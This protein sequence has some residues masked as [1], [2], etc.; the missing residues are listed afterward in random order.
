MKYVEHTHFE[1]ICSYKYNK[2]VRS[3]YLSLQ[4]RVKTKVEQWQ[5]L[6]KGKLFIKQDDRE[7]T[8]KMTEELDKNI[9]KKC[10]SSIFQQVE[11][12][13][14]TFK[15]QEDPQKRETIDLSFYQGDGGD[16]RI[17]EI[18]PPKDQHQDQEQLQKKQQIEY[19]ACKFC[20]QEQYPPIKK[21]DM[22]Q[23]LTL[24]PNEDATL[25]CLILQKKFEIK[26][27]ILLSE[28]Y[29]NESIGLSKFRSDCIFRLDDEE[30]R[31]NLMINLAQSSLEE[32]AQDKTLHKTS[33]FQRVKQKNKL[34]ENDSIVQQISLSETVRKKREKGIISEA[35]QELGENLQSLN[36]QLILFLEDY[37]NP[38]LKDKKELH[39]FQQKLIHKKSKIPDD[40]E[41]NP[42]NPQP[43]ADPDDTQKTHLLQQIYL[44]IQS[45]F[46]IIILIIFVI[47]HIKNT[48]LVSLVYPFSF[49]L[50][51]MIEYPYPS[52]NYW[53]L[54]LTY[55]IAIIVIKFIYQVPIFC[56]SPAYTLST[57]N[58]C[59]NIFYTQSE[60]IVRIDYLIGIK[61][62]SG[63]SS[64]PHD[65]GFFNAVFWDLIV[66]LALLFQ[67]YIMQEQGLWNYVAVKN[68]DFYIPQFLK[69][70]KKE[71]QR[72]KKRDEENANSDSYL[73]NSSFTSESSAPS[74]SQKEDGALKKYLMRLNPKQLPVSPL[75]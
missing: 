2:V 68:S 20:L 74:E 51:A 48:N 23:L 67:R 13:K 53:K 29:P 55:T 28:I 33:W 7:L 50:Y 32:V 25:D 12:E 8:K 1:K 9:L 43:Q 58:S 15:P 19:K 42:Q 59:Q 21:K 54:I 18:Q 3:T 65:Q 66:L 10:S 70:S 4:Q 35:F 62:Y 38:I 57:S 11:E 40:F 63:P 46:E 22:I 71:K 34:K 14:Q 26:K 17:S 6:L 45:H 47:N 52:K 61:K 64:F 24:Y 16:F 69:P 36:K 30:Q 39:S 31:L 72:R 27:K 73:E 49:F 44:V 5:Q 37:I 60:I 56:G 41:P 75:P